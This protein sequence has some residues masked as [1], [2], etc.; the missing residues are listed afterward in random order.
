MPKTPE[1]SSDRHGVPELEAHEHAEKAAERAEV[2]DE[3][4]AAHRDEQESEHVA[5][6]EHALVPRAA[7]IVGD[8][9]DE[10][11]ATRDASEEGVPDHEVVPVR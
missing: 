2:E 1:H 11:G 4:D 6:A 9:R 3:E 10:V 8:G 5:D 7:E